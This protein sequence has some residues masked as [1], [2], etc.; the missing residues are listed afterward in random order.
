MEP[1]A[2][3]ERMKQ[4]DGGYYIGENPLSPAIGDVKISFH[5]VTPTIISA[6]GEQRNNSLVP[7][8]T[9]SGE[10]LALLEYGTVSM[11]KMFTIAEQEN[12]ALTWLARFGGFI[13]MTFG[14]LATFYIFEVITRVLP[15]FGRLINAGLLILSVFLSA[16]L[17]IITI[18]LG[19]IAH[20]PI[21]AYSLIAIAVLF[22]VFSIFKV[23]KANPGIDDD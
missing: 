23:M 12:I 18:A 4:Y 7:Y 14:F 22:F 16:S 2:L 9:S 6:I 5:I 8:S 19:W 13:L 20:R 17:S 21:I 11:G 10:S 15:F 3:N 1:L